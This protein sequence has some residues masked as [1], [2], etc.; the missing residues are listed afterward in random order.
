[1]PGR[2]CLPYHLRA[3]YSLNPALGAVSPCERT[4][5]AAPRRAPL[6]PS[7]PCARRLRFRRVYRRDHLELVKHADLVK[8]PTVS[9]TDRRRYREYEEQQEESDQG[10]E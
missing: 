8:R 4:E 10:H 2:S 3:D 6:I 9:R 1:M 5:E 7:A